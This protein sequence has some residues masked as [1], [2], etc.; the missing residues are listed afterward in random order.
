MPSR[1]GVPEESPDKMD[2]E[3]SELGWELENLGYGEDVDAVPAAVR[4]REERDWAAVAFGEPEMEIRVSDPDVKRGEVLS[5]LRVIQFARESA[6]T[7][8][9]QK[10]ISHLMR[11]SGFTREDVMD[12]LRV[13]YELG[14]DTVD[15][16]LKGEGVL[17]AERE[18]VRERVARLFDKS[19]G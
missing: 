3:S 6:N 7:V 9:E 11:A 14:E 17:V 19:A 5:Y 15:D 12:L 18:E 4:L 10:K 2:F 16:L 8:R 1:Q 13:Y